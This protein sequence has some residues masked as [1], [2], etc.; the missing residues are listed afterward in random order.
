MKTL[1]LVGAVLMA[2]VG[3]ASA[4][5]YNPALSKQMLYYASATFC[6]EYS[7]Q[8]WYCGPACQMTQGVTKVTLVSEIFQG[9]F[10]FVNYNNIN[11][12]INVAF[13]GSANLANWYLDLDYFF[14][15][16]LTGPQGA[17]VHRGFYDAYYGLSY[18]VIDAVKSLL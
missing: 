18:Q 12:T 15:P 5:D 6:D 1:S 10:G 8:N 7:L 16:Y 2:T 11:N 13:R 4:D 17:E 3:F 9:T 14:T